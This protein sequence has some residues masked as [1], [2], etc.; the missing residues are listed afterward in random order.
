MNGYTAASANELK[1]EY[2]KKLFP[3]LPYARR[4][5]MAATVFNKVTCSLRTINIKCE[6][7]LGLTC[8]G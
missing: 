7:N 5:K 6:V 1:K 3:M 2:K 8:C 4:H